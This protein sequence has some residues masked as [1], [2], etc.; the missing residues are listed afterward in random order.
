M[1]SCARSCEFVYMLLVNFVRSR[2]N[3]N[4]FAALLAVRDECSAIGEIAR[5]TPITVALAAHSD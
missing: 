2:R 1:H 3:A 4:R 5:S